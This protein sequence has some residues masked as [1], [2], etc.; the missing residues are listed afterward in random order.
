MDIIWPEVLVYV[1]SMMFGLIIAKVFEAG[2][3]VEFEVS[4][5][6]SVKQPKVSHLHCS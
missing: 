2:L 3:L 6:F 1:G 4:L 5:R